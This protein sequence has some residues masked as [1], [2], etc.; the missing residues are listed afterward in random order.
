MK[1]YTPRT[2]P[3]DYQ[4]DVIDST[5]TAR[6]WA[7]F[8]EQR[9]GKSKVTVDT[10]GR[11][12]AEGW[13]D[14]VL[15]IA[16]NGVH[17]AWVTGDADAGD[18]PGGYFGQHLP[19]DMP[20]R[21]AYWRA[22]ER[23]REREAR[24]ALYEPGEAL[25]VL[26]LNVEG[27][28]PAQRRKRGSR[29]FEEAQRLLRAYATLLI[30]DESTT[31]KNGKAKRSKAVHALA[32][33]AAY[34]RILAGEPAPEGPQDLYSQLRVIDAA[35]LGHKSYLTFR[36]EFCKVEQ[37]RFPHPTKPGQEVQTEII[38]GAKNEAELSRRLANVATTLRRE[39]LGVEPPS[40]VTNRPVELSDEQRRAYNQ[41]VNEWCYELDRA[42][43][44][45]PIDVTNAMTRLT[46]M[47]QLTGGH[48]VDE[49]G[50]DSPFSKN[51][52]LEALVDELQG[53]PQGRKAIV[54]CRY[55]PELRDI[56][57]RLRQEFGPDAVVEYHGGIGDDDREQAVARFQHGDASI[58]VANPQAGRYGL[59]LSAAD[60]VIW[61][62]WGASYE[63]YDQ[64]CDRPVVPGQEHEIQYTHLVATET[65]DAKLLGAVRRKEDVA[66][67]LRQSTTI[68]DLISR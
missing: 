15:V 27:L 46:R 2:E 8:L 66:K 43:D 57:R 24:E 14:A 39:D 13:I 55:R 30:V 28:T 54:W 62:S 7:L 61:F 65:V 11:L 68:R 5:V 48:L 32:K 45:E 31:V 17:R 26:S 29:S 12:Y 59:T 42:G 23:K 58:I 38:T 18:D 9:L 22:Q 64:A 37:K 25:R 51:P 33:D 52:K 3:R 63:D 35:P 56:P 53:V 16:P 44:D 41:L 34:T 49:N 67:K 50:A 10:A 21:L 20:R 6:H 47:Q 60:H 40:T 19:E 4:R 36:G 1:R